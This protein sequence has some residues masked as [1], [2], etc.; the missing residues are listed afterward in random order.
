MPVVL[1]LAIVTLVVAVEINYKNDVAD[2]L[3]DLAGDKDKTHDDHS[4][5]NHH[6]D[7]HDHTQHEEMHHEGHMMKMWFHFGADE[8]ILFDFWRTDSAVGMLLSCITIFV[9]GATY[10]GV[11]WFRMYLLSQANNNVLANRSCIEFQLQTPRARAPLTQT[12]S[13]RNTSQSHSKLITTQQGEPFITSIVPTK[14]ISPFAIERIMEA[15]LYIFQ[16]ILAYWLMLIVMTY[17][18]YLTL[19]VIFGA[20]FGHWLF[21]VL[22]L[23]NVD[24]EA[25]DS[26]QTDACH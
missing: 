7:S 23:R 13:S 25:A 11:K 18:V 15:F 21:A 17:N 8:V 1:L 26:F 10:E 9:M 6:A 22:Q 24:I 3:N 12:A 5:H 2:F 16:L 14:K 4:S 20:G 19:A